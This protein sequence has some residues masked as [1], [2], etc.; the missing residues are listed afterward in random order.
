M[1]VENEREHRS[2]QPLEGEPVERITETEVKVAL[3]KMKNGKSVG[4]DNIPA[5]VWKH[6]GNTGVELLTK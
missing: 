4:P 1:N 3:R 6:L 5:E 2:I